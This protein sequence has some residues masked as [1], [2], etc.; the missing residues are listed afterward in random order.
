L[1]RAKYNHK[2]KQRLNRLLQILNNKKV[3]VKI[4]DA[5]TAAGERINQFGGLICFTKK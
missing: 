2:Q 5:K 4:I 1:I 3:N